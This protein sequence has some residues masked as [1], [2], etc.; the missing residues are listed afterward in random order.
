MIVSQKP[1]KIK[2]SA[3]PGPAP[4][5]DMIAFGPRARPAYRAPTREIRLMRNLIRSAPAVLFLAAFVAATTV[6]AQDDLTIEKILKELE[7]SASAVTNWSADVEMT[8]NM[9][10]MTMLMS[11]SQVASGSRTAG[12]MKMEAMG[13]LITMNTVMGGDGLAWIEMDMMGQKQVMKMDVKALMDAQTGPMSG[14]MGLDPTSLM[15]NNPKDLL[16]NYAKMFD[17]SVKGKETLNDEEVYVLEA[18]LDDESRSKLDPTG[19]LASMG[20]GIHK[21]RLAVGVKDGFLRQMAM[22]GPNDAPFM[23]TTYKNLKL[24]I[25][26]AEST[27][28]YT[29][30]EGVMVMDMTDMAKAAAESQSDGEPESKFKTGDVAPDFEGAG[31]DGKTVKLSDYRGKVVLIDFWAT[32]CAPCVKELPNVIAAYESFH[33]QGFEIIGISLD[34]ERE[35]LEKFLKERPAMA[36]PQIFDGKGWETPIAELYGVEAIP[37]TLLL[38]RTGKITHLDLRGDDLKNFLPELLK[39]AN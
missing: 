23:S 1:P 22:L 34:D 35:D 33:D 38:D 11:G 28:A 18:A 37:N 30:P 9:M 20:M 16:A 3:K 24:N 10:G 39:S 6:P 4:A 12:T 26:V 31:L 17:L 36:W 21:F 25:D 14:S 27:F 29:P 2:F 5:Y 7:A 8:M 19:A 13:Q 32:W 15:S